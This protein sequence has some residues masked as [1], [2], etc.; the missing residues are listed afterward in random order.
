MLYRK[1]LAVSALT[2]L[3][4]SPLATAH[5]AGDFLIRTGPIVVAPNDSSGHIRITDP[6]LGDVQGT[7]VGVD[8]DTQLGLSFTYMLRPYLGVELLA[9]TPFQHDIKATGAI[10]GLGK[11][12]STK[13]LPPTLTLQ[14]YPLGGA[15]VFQ[16]YV[17]IGVNYTHFFQE[18]TTDALTNNIGTLAQLQGVSGVTATSSTMKLQD[19]FGVAAELG[20]DYKL[21]DRIGLNAGIWWANIETTA[22][23]KSQTNVGEV[24]SKVDVNI[25]P[26]V[27]MVGAYFKF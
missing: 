3:A 10:S 20:A 15:S 22:T 6:N 14:Y 24:T 21:T 16:P 5:D 8:S 26:M 12:G 18:H 4:F 7:G 1:L 13:Q 25:N 23:I 11:L 19:S 9:A 17:G 27:Y 2:S